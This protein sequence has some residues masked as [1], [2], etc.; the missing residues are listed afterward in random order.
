MFSIYV[1]IPYCRAICAYCDF[2]V[3]PAARMPEDRYTAALIRELDHAS[4]DA[5]W[6]G[7]VVASV[8]LGGGTP[9]LFR[10]ESIARVIEAVRQRWCV[11]SSV[12][13][14]LEATPAE[15]EAPTLRA[16]R[17][18]GVNRLSLGVQSFAPEYLR[19][20]T[21][22]HTDAEA[23]A[24]VGTAR[25]AGFDNV[26][27]DLIFAIP[28]QTPADWEAG[29]RTACGLGPEH[30]STYGLTYEEGTPFHAWREKGRV[31]PVPE[32]TE[33]LMFTRTRELLSAAGY[34]QYEISNYAR[35]GRKSRHNLNCWQ[36]VN[37]LGVGS[38]AHSYR[39]TGWGERWA[40][41]RD[42]A[43]Y[44]AAVEARGEARASVEHLSR[45]QAM[46]ECAFLSLRQR[47]GIDAREF[48][49]RFGTDLEECL[50]ALRA[51]R[52]EGLLAPTAEGYRLTAAGMLLSDSV[53]ASFL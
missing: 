46:G 38:G 4:R 41:A 40:N 5:S 1:N 30:L 18:S 24:A 36:G 45:A 7:D 44:M 47:R 14:T 3:R 25:E 2:P 49:R 6:R 15:V 43:D 39:R 51:L 32:E 33:A 31:L 29:L 13:V 11:A 8:Y 50:P 34:R 48:R 23:R 9:S 17:A 37:Y 21:R 16:F 28:G 22:H 20:L 52:S 53:F 19:R 35:P 42:P 27:L 10:P 12:E 26:N